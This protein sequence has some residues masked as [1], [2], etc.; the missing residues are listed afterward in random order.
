M[1]TELIQGFSLVD[2]L[3]VL[4]AL[5]ERE[6]KVVGAMSGRE[7]DYEQLAMG[8]F[9]Q[10][11]MGWTIIEKTTKQPL[12]VA[13]FLQVGVRTFRSFFYATQLAWDEFGS[14]LTEHTREVLSKLTEQNEVIR[15]E[16]ITLADEE[17]ARRWYEAVGLTFES[18]LTCYGA[19]GEKAVIY[20]KTTEG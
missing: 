18:E 11:A 17:Q 7:Y 20:V 2:A 3:V 13:G 6:R 1:K 15:L 14:E 5:P 9:Q 16:T 4:R 12:V 8:I 19:N 10:S